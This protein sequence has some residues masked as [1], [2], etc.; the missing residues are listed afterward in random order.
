MTAE[1][2]IIDNT[3]TDRQAIVKA[4]CMPSS[5]PDSFA[6]KPLK[7]SGVGVF[8]GDKMPENWSLNGQLEIGTVYPIY[9]YEGDFIIGKDGTGLKFNENDWKEIVWF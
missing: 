4:L 2:F 3:I 7:P 1:E 5:M 9:S 6:I 8:K